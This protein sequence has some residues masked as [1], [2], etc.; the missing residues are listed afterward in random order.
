LEDE[1]SI[2][3]EVPTALADCDAPMPDKLLVLAEEVME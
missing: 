2:R 1:A 3:L